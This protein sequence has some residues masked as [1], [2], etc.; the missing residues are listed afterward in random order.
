MN[1][2][3]IFR[4]GIKTPASSN[5]YPVSTIEDRLSMEQAFYNALKQLRSG[6]PRLA[7]LLRLGDDEEIGFWNNIVDAK[8]LSRLAK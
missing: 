2:R 5:K 6:I 1:G 3:F 4:F 8:L 7:D